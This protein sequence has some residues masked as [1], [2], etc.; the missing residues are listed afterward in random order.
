LDY[1][2]SVEEMVPAAGQGALALQGRRGEDYGFLDAVRDPVSEE[3][4]A[5]ERFFIQTLD[6]GCGSPAAAHARISG[7]EI[8]LTGIYAADPVSPLFRETL[9]GERRKALFLAQSL[10]RTLVRKAAGGGPP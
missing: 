6:C 3:E 2:F 10:A 7:N 4:T 5:A 9:R 8:S 1:V